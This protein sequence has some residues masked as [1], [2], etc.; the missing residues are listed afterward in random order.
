MTTYRATLDPG[1]SA[2]ATDNRELSR[3]QDQQ[4][5]WLWDIG[6]QKPEQPA[7]PK[8]PKGREG[9]PEYELSLVDFRHELSDYETAME[10]FRV[11]RAEHEEW[12]RRCG[13][14][15]QLVM[16]SCDAQDA[17]A[18]DPK[19]YFISSRTRG[20]A[21]LPNMGLPEAAPKPGHGYAEQLRRE[22]EGEEEFAAIRKADPVFGERQV[23]A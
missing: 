1:S 14:P 8:A 3:D 17:L 10:R 22:Q 2:V 6:P 12:Q 7:K 4:R 9:D 5:V 20:Y 23:A 19:R 21:G 16:W 13:G 11:L 15:I 18:R